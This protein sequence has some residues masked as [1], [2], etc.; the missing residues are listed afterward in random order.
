MKYRRI[1]RAVVALD[2]A[3]AL[4]AP[5]VVGEAALL[6]LQGRHQLEGPEPAF[7]SFGQVDQDAVVPL[8][9]ARVGDEPTAQV[10][11]E[12][13]VHLPEGAPHVGLALVEPLRL[14]HA[15]ILAIGG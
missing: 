10:G 8:G 12:L 3:A 7:R 5:E 14:G 1:A 15:D 2:Q 4:H 6:P 13:G 11:E 9:Q